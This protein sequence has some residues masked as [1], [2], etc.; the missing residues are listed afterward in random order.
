M[1]AIL[2]VPNVRVNV[3][4]YDVTDSNNLWQTNHIFSYNRIH[5]HTKWLMLCVCMRAIVWLYC[6]FFK[7]QMNSFHSMTIFVENIPITRIFCLLLLWRFSWIKKLYN[8]H[9]WYFHFLK[10]KNA[11]ITSYFLLILLEILSSY[12]C[13][14]CCYSG[15]FSWKYKENTKEKEIG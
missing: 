3:C 5:A 10:E 7:L 8:S 9:Y 6:M 2:V 1:R 14:F 4:S 15:I 13:P 12:P 11:Q